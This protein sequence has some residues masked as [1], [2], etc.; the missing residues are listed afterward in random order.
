MT[1]KLKKESLNVIHFNTFELFLAQ[2]KN[3]VRADQRRN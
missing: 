1:L 2:K 3:F